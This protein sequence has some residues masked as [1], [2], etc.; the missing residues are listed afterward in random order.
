MNY[1]TSG[2][3]SKPIPAL[4]LKLFSMVKNNTWKCMNCVATFAV[5]ISLMTFLGVGLGV[6]SPYT[7]T[8]H[9]SQEI[10]TCTVTSL[11]ELGMVTC[12]CD[13]DE[14]T[15]CESGHPCAEILVDY[16]SQVN[17]SRVGNATLYTSPYD[18][19]KYMELKVKKLHIYLLI[20]FI[21]FYL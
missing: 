4:I 15:R 9:F 20:S 14:Y 21:V 16:V 8:R 2:E 10:S 5:V 17:R 13:K 1:G 7:Q 11:R 18:Y 3:G 12:S 19:A 6:V